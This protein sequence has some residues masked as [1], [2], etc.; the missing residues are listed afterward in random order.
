MFSTTFSNTSFSV[1]LRFKFKY[2]TSF[3]KDIALLGSSSTNRSTIIFPFFILPA[4]FIL[5]PML[6]D[7]FDSSTLLLFDFKK[8]LSPSLGLLLISFNPW[9]TITLFSS[10]KGIISETVAN[11]TKSRR[12]RI[13]NLFSDFKL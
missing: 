13:F 5:G 2:S 10:I 4:A 7:I 9:N 8:F 1:A 12:L 11:A 3:D 6:N